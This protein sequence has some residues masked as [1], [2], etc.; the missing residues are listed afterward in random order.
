MKKILIILM[1]YPL[2]SFSQDEDYEQFVLS[3][4][5]P[6]EIRTKFQLHF[7]EDYLLNKNLNPFYLRGDFNGDQR[8]DYA[9]SVINKESKKTGI[10]IFHTLTPEK[11]L[12]GGGKK[13]TNRNIDQI[14]WSDA[15]QVYPNGPVEIGVGETEQIALKGDAILSLKVEASSVLF[16]WTGQEY[17]VYQQGD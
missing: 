1:I 8:I 5:L 7:S 14:Y 12:I 2:L 16:Y 10:V 6:A 15:W 9:I 13:L 11:F 17:K 4:S 3:S